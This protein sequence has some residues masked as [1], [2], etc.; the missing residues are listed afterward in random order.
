ML[1]N[2]TMGCDSTLID[3]FL[4][5][6]IIPIVLTNSSPFS[7]DGAQGTNYIDQHAELAGQQQVLARWTIDGCNSICFDMSVT[8]NEPTF[9]EDVSPKFFLQ[10]LPQ[11][12]RDQAGKSAPREAES[13]FVSR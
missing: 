8:L 1:P 6:R 4:K 3:H 5:V 9:S 2:W 11:N 10:S 13:Y 12:Q 7:I